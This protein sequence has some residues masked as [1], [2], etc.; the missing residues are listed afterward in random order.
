MKLNKSL[1]YIFI[2][3]VLISGCKAVEKK[4]T[5]VENNIE[6]IVSCGDDSDLKKY[7][8]EG[9]TIKQE[10]S[11]EKV[12]SWKTVAASKDCNLEK[13]KG[14]KIV[15]PDRVGEEKVFLLEKK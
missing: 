9:W 6:I 3:F 13:D 14:C 2:I 10:Y 5:E 1:T 12:C 11:E 7:L 4:V 8:N 15:K